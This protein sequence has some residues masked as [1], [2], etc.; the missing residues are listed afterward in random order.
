MQIMATLVDYQS[1]KCQFVQN[2][3]GHQASFHGPELIP[4]QLLFN[5]EKSLLTAWK[6]ADIY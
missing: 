4:K 1:S 6:P 5:I 2:T 3:M